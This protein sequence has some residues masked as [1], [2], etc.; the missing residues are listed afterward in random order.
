MHHLHTPAGAGMLLLAALL[1]LLVAPFLS[2]F[3]GNKGLI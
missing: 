2:T 3:T 1:A